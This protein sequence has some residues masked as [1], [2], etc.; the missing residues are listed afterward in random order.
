MPETALPEERLVEK[1][2]PLA[3]VNA[4]GKR[5]AGFIRVP[6]INNLHTWWARRPA[7]TARVL[8][9]ASVLPPEPD[10]VFCRKPYLF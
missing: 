7:G 1:W 2:L 4:Y 6:K 8:N 3:E 10:D 5:E 9:L